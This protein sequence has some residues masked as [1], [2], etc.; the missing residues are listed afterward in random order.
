M[1]ENFVKPLNAGIS[2]ENGY[3]SHDGSSGFGISAYAG[4]LNFSFWKKG[5]KSGDN[6]DN[7]LSLNINQ[8]IIFN[9]YLKYI[10]TTRNESY[11]AGGIESYDDISNLKLSIDGF[12][13]G[14]ITNFGIIQFDTVEIEGVK[15]VQ[16]TVTRGNTINSVIFCDLILKNAIPNNVKLKYDILDTSFMRF[17]TDI[18]NWVNFAWHQAA[19][20]K[21][22]NTVVGKRNGDSGNGGRS[23]G[24]STSQRRYNS[25]SNDSSM[26]EDELN[27]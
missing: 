5:E 21:L 24:G 1:P 20:N 3:F 9:N 17:C 16:L 26:Y 12:V 19:T 13:N 10:I 6:R 8:T 2:L 14:Q 11:Q 7:K 18:N 27:F 4:R 15:R 22:F 23:S 25:D